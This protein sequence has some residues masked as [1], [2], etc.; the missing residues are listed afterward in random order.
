VAATFYAELFAIDPSLRRMFSTDM[1]VLGR[2]LMEMLGRIVASLDEPETIVPE[3]RELALRHLGYGV[4]AHHYT[5]AGTALLRTMRHE[6][7]DEFTPEARAAWAA[8]YQFIS[9][10]MRE[11][12]YGPEASRAP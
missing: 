10:T 11:A 8:A 6:L 5:T 12:A 1:I 7:G 3:V 4:E 9:D 2:K